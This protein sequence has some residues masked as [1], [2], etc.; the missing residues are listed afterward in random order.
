MNARPGNLTITPRRPEYDVAKA[1]RENRYWQ[2]GDPVLTHF[3]NAL[4]A[5]FP[6]G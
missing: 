1:M 3:V 5:T 2:G 4:Q 6:E